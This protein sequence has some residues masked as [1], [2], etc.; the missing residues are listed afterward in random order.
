MASLSAVEFTHAP[1]SDCANNEA[2]LNISTMLI[3]LDTSHFEM[4][5]LKDLA[6]QNMDRIVVTLD[7]SHFERSALKDAA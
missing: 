5:A 7:T 6:F 3:T 2:P 4:S 1:Q